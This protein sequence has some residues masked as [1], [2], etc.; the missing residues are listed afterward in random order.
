MSVEPDMLTV[1]A[2]TLLAPDVEL[3]TYGPQVTSC[4]SLLREP[5]RERRAWLSEEPQ[6]AQKEP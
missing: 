4:Y 6:L 2:G 1:G 3:F 5:R